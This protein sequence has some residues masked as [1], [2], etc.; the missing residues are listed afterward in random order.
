MMGATLATTTTQA[1]S[2]ALIASAFAHICALST[3]MAA[4]AA[5]KTR[6]D[7]RLA[8]DNRKTAFHTPN[9]QIMATRDS[10]NTH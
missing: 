6:S 7:L 10:H 2:Q 4:S 8:H 9:H 1:A 3:K 5:P